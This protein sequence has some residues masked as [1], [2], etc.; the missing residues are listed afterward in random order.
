MPLLYYLLKLSVSIAL[1]Y[2]F[3]WFLLRRLTFYYWNRW[4]LLLFGMLSLVFPF[5]NINPV[6]EKAEWNQWQLVNAIPSMH[7]YTP[8]QQALPEQ[9]TGS[10]SIPGVAYWLTVV[11]VA[12]ILL[13]LL[14]LLMQYVS[15]QKMKRGASVSQ[16]GGVT[17][18]QVNESIVPFSFGNAIFINPAQ[19]NGVELKEIIRHEF[20]H[21][22]Q[23]HHVDIWVSELLCLLNWFNPFAWWLRRALKQN[24]EFIADHHVL[25]SGVDKKEYQ[26]LLLKVMGN[27]HFSIA[28]QFNFSSLK[29]R[30]AMMNKLKSTP[31]HLL[32]FLFAVPLLAV[33]LLAFRNNHSV[34]GSSVPVVNYAVLVIDADSKQ[35]VPNVLVKEEYSGLQWR[36][37]N[38]GYVQFQFTDSRQAEFVLLFS[39]E[40]YQQ[41]NSLMVLTK[42]QLQ[43]AVSLVE[44]V[45][46]KKGGSTV[47]CTDCFSTV[48]MKYENQSQIGYKEVKEYYDEW[49]KN[50]EKSVDAAEPAAM[51]YT[52]L[53]DKV[54]WLAGL[55]VDENSM[56]PLNN[57][58]IEC[59]G[60]KIITYTDERGYYEIK[61]PYE[62]RPLSFV[63]HVSKNGYGTVQQT[64]N[65]GNF[66]EAHIRNRYSF[67]AELF[68]LKKGG[69]G[70]SS[71]LAGS[72]PEKK[73]LT[74]E[75]VLAQLPLLKEAVAGD[76]EIIEAPAPPAAPPTGK[77]TAPAS[78]PMAPDV[79]TPS[80]SAMAPAPDEIE[81]NAPISPTLEIGQ[82]WPKNVKQLRVRNDKATVVLKNGTK[83]NYDLSKP[84][85]K[86]AFEKKYG[87]VLPPPPP[88]PPAK[89]PRLSKH[90]S[91]AA[92]N[93]KG[94]KITV[95]DNSGECVVIIKNRE[96]KI[97]KA[98]LLT[99]WNGRE[100]Y[101]TGLY[102][103]ML[104]NPVPPDAVSEQVSL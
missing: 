95:A 16:Y 56:E 71:A 69:T 36:A 100:K 23:R 92:F 68:A 89:A 26:Y 52:R 97:V 1:V 24:L 11:V 59:V 63:L 13:M 99:E 53:Q 15:L 35:P 29:K 21:V 20:V 25:Q 101:Y 73:L 39:K 17:I 54:V 37:D 83:E 91:E 14:R 62:N 8:V 28:N 90:A 77:V 46:I 67:S 32:I 98:V 40:G 27:A 64:E 78:A 22:K 9:T 44:L 18:Y 60:K 33:L 93:S 79:P 84:E 76:P 87:P 12:G 42:Q 104:P 58:K 74:Y 41:T 45:S 57:V 96:E 75:Y 43:Q 34:T 4:F 47:H 7:V 80:E 70:G 102:G 2:L 10:P 48:S 50:P 19:H 103:V 86:K 55:V 6:L 85:E 30:I 51:A 38:N 81:I 49:M 94:Y 61:I 72:V 65:W 5:I 82:E 88:P 3:Y 66:Y 31:V